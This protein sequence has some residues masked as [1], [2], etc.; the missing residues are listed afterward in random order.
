MSQLEPRLKEKWQEIQQ[1]HAVPVSMLGKPINPSDTEALRVWREEGIDRFLRKAESETKSPLGPSSGG[2][3]KAVLAG[4]VVLIAAGIVAGVWFGRNSIGPQAAAPGPNERGVNDGEI[5]LGMS[6]AF[7]GPAQELGKGMRAGIEA[8]FHDINDQGGIHGRKLSLVALD[9]GYEPDR[10]QANMAELIERRGI[11][12]V[13]GNV[14]TPTTQAALPYVLEKKKIFFGAFTGA[15][16][17]RNN[18]PDHYVLNYRASYA[19]ETAAMVRYLVEKKHTPPD[20]IAVLTQNDGYGLAGFRGVVRALDGY[21][22]S[23]DKI[24]RVNYERNTVSVEPA[25]QEILAHRDHVRA[26]VMVPTYKPAAKFVQLLK[27]QKLEAT[28]AAVSFVNSE[29]LA[30]EFRKVGPQYGEGV[31]VTQVVPF[32]KQVAAND[33]KVVGRYETCL[34]RYS[35]EVNPSFISLEGFIAAHLFAEGLNRAGRNFSTDSLIQTF[36]S[37]KNLDLG[38]GTTIGFSPTEHQASHRVWG[39]VLDA[40]GQYQILD[41]E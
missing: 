17:L 5:V 7:S 15:D 35:P 41:V 29:A 39:T 20:Q 6:A 12:A 10:C 25:V 22:V 11:F 34:K 26:I 18:P 8:C 13:I 3:K 21:G 9:D 23:A 36:E 2:K 4:T 37:I 14:G 1:R 33:A 16:L 40:N 19:E 28:F 38:I 32:Y 24:L 31:I 30:A 27:D